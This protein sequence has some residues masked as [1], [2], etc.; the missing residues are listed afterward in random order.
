MVMATAGIS[1][2]VLILLLRVILGVAWAN[3]GTLT[4]LGALFIFSGAQFL[5]FGLMGEYIGRIYQQVR[6]REHYLVRS[7]ERPER[8]GRVL[9]RKSAEAPTAAGARAGRP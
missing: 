2:G 4:L 3:E 9:D 7:V 5:A 8:I 1:L 6:L